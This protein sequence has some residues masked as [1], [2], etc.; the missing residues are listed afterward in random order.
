MQ[1]CTWIIP[2]QCINLCRQESSSRRNPFRSA[3][4]LE[5]CTVAI[6]SFLPLS[7]SAERQEA[8]L[9]GLSCSTASSVLY[10][11]T[12]T[13]RSII[14]T[15][16]RVTQFFCDFY[17]SRVL[18]NGEDKLSIQFLK[19]NRTNNVR[20]GGRSEKRPAQSETADYSTELR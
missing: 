19:S 11:P 8:A 3:V 12:A 1:N 17:Q 13:S 5:H 2:T 16:C 9:N 14:A 15:N 4:H 6:L 7:P 20:L 18:A 10:W